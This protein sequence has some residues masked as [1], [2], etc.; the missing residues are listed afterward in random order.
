MVAGDLTITDYLFLGDYVDRGNWNLEVLCL[1]LAL[2]VHY[3]QNIFLIRGNHE[4]A[5]INKVYGFY[6]ECCERLGQRDGQRVWEAANAMFQ[7]LPMAAVIEDKILC[8][9]GGIG[10]CITVGAGA[11]AASRSI[12][13]VLTGARQSSRAAEAGADR[14]A[15]AAAGGQLL[16]GPQGPTYRQRAAL[17]GPNGG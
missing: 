16:G 10:D 14:A 6:S 11:K 4:I 9:H 2:K 5:E 3:P 1:L 15:G 8:M 17:V 12:L 7:W 13:L